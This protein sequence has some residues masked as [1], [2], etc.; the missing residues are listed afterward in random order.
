M[1]DS[2]SDDIKDVRV[3]AHS[4]VLPQG[5]FMHLVAEVTPGVPAAR[6]PGIS[7]TAMPGQGSAVA[8]RA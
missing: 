8:S 5:K 4:I 3:A 1:A 2:A 7:V 6:L